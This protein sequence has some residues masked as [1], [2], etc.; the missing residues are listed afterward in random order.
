MREELENRLIDFT[1]AI[2]GMVY[3]L[4]AGL[5]SQTIGL[6]IIRSATSA[7]LNFGEA[8]GAES[9]RDFI[10]KMS[11]VLKELRETEINLKIILRSNQSENEIILITIIEECKQLVAIFQKSLNTARKN[12][13]TN[14]NE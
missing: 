14:L 13:K 12:I 4:K 6:Q 2:N 9:R 11:V 1:V 8:Q 5:L 10:H 3:G 7:T